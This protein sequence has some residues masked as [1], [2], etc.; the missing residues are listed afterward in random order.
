MAQVQYDSHQRSKA[1][2]RQVLRRIRVAPE[3][4]AEVDSK[5]PDWFDI[6]EASG[7]LQSYGLT[8]D[9]AISRLGGSP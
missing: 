7:L 5:L 1:E 4:I 2:L 6:D 8:C 3:T 9:E